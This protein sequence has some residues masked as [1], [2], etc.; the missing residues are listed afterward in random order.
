MRERGM[1][2]TLGRLQ[3]DSNFFR[4]GISGRNREG[5]M[6]EVIV[7]QGSHEMKWKEGNKPGRKCMELWD[8]RRRGILGGANG[9]PLY[10]TIL[11]YYYVN[12][13]CKLASYRKLVCL[14]QQFKTWKSSHNKISPIPHALVDSSEGQCQQ[15]S[16]SLVW[17]IWSHKGKE[18]QFEI[19][20]FIT[21]PLEN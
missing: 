13:Y 8:I 5:C 3:E 1:S 14:S 21:N 9:R 11:Y 15:L 18:T 19:L 7:A 4:L 10:T 20:T 17:V 16:G 12:V 6:R 2:K